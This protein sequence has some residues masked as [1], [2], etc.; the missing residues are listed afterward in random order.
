MSRAM[1]YAAA[2]SA[3]ASLL[4]ASCAIETSLNPKP[5]PVG[6]PEIT[7][8]FVSRPRPV[9]NV[10]VKL[11]VLAPVPPLAIAVWL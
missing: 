1:P 8:E 6:V 2:L 3:L 9:G 5:E 4:L 10:P 11:K 7:P